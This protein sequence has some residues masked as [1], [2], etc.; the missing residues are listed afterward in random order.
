MR[1]RI[2]FRLPPRSSFLKDIPAISQVYVTA[3]ALLCL[4]G[5]EVSQLDLR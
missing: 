3:G 5:A 2:Q 1:H 4:V